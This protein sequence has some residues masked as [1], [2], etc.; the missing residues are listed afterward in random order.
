LDIHKA[1]NKIAFFI[2]IRI[3]LMIAIVHVLIIQ[4]LLSLIL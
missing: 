3:A 4:N 2:A 1:E